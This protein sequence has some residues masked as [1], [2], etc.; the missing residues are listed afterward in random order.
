LS[1]RARRALAL[2]AA[3]ALAG[4][5]LV[6]LLWESA[7]ERVGAT[8]DAMEEALDARDADALA[9]WFEEEVE[10]ARPIPGL[11]MRGGLVEAARRFLAGTAKVSFDRDTTEL[12]FPQEGE[13]RVKTRGV[14]SITH[15]ELGTGLFRFEAEFV[16]REAADGRFL[17]AAVERVRPS[18]YP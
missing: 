3:L 5:F 12:E 4:P 16:L 6:D 18:P 13:A 2:V 11:S 14:G 8:L 1:S 17:L 7:E 15:P 9:E 10:V